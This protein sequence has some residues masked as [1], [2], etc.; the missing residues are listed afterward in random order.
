MLRLRKI[1]LCNYIYITIFILILIITIIRLSIPNKSHIKGNSFTGIITKIEIKED[2]TN[3]YIT[4]KETIIA[5]TYNMHQYLCNRIGSYPLV[6]PMSEVR[7]TCIL[8]IDISYNRNL[9]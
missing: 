3:L 6:C 2:K 1:L 5:Y 9:R 8:C 4:N 7:R